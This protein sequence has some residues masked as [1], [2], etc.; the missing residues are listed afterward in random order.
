MK[1]FFDEFFK[2][3]LFA[4]FLIVLGSYLKVDTYLNKL[5]DLFS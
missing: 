5:T 4:A 3:Y 2:P 1:K